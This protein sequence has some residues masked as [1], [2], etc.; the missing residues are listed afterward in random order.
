MKSSKL[1]LKAKILCGVL[2]GGVILSAGSSAFAASENASDST[3]NSKI[4]YR[5]PMDRNKFN[6]DKMEEMN[7]VF[8]SVLQEAVKSNTITQDESNKIK[9]YTDKKAEEAK[10]FIQQRKEAGKKEGIKAPKDR[11]INKSGKMGKE[12]KGELF[13]DLVKEGILTQEKADI[14]R[15]NVHKKTEALRDAKLKEDLS[16]LVENKTLTQDKANKIT[17]AIKAANDT[18]KADFEKFKNMTDEERREYMKGIKDSYKDPIK[19][20]VENGTITE[21]QEKEVRKILPGHQNKHHAPGV[22]G[23]IHGNKPVQENTSKQ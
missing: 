7:K 17:A 16:K 5:V 22:K 13:E 1:S 18:R 4:E 12:G 23:K 6:K 19:T 3:Q 2:A 11:K 20:L 9:A 21:A 14:L 15:E 8:E 10:Q